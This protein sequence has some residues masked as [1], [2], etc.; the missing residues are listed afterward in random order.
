MPNLVPPVTTVSQAL[1][2]EKRL[3][4]LDSTVTYLMT[5]YLHP[6]ITPEVVREAKKAGIAGIKSYP[7]GLTTNS[8]SG[9]TSY[10]EFYPV[11]AVMEEVGMVLVSA[12]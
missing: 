12:S 1:E 2:Y 11:F 9:V 3:K 8:E 7:Q 10:E 5:L 6:S 4:A